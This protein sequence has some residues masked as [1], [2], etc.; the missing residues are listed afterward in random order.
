VEHFEQS[1]FYAV[2]A[3]PPKRFT[4]SPAVRK[5]VALK[6]A[7]RYTVALVLAVTLG[8]HVFPQT[9]NPAEIPLRVSRVFGL[10]LVTA[11]INGKPAVLI[12]DT[13]SNHTIV[14]SRFVDVATPSLKDTVNNKKGSGLSGTG[15]FTRASLKVGP[16]LWRDHRILAMDMKEMSKSFGENID[17]LLG[18][19]FLEQFETV[20]VDL[21]QHKLILSNPV[22]SPPST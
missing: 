6:T 7:C 2:T 3:E 13:G 20:V 11:E 4:E 19:D 21:R 1:R 8:F 5:S 15:V 12:L 10:M 9:S 17:G 16:L 18:M 14:S 22:L